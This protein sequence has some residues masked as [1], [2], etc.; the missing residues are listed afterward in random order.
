M[1]FLLFEIGGD[2]YCLEASRVIEVTPMVSFRSL[3]HAPAYV[4]GL[5]NYRGTVTPVIDLSALLGRQPSRSF[6]STRIILVDIQG[7]G[8]TRPILGLLAERVTETISRRET[9]F[10]PSGIEIE[11]ARF[12][13]KV[14]FDEKGRMIQRLELDEILPEGVRKSLYPEGREAE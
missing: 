10:Q 1:L 8:K 4:S 3:P 2:C 5:M 7:A 13:G 9:E 11:D 14:A 12:M 6:F